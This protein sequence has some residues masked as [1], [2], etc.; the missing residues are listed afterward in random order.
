MQHVAADRD[1]Q[2]LDPSLV[3]ADGQRVEQRLRRML[4]RAVAGID[5]LA[6]FFVRQ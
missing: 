1:D 4:V 6:V 5:E 2:A 3:A